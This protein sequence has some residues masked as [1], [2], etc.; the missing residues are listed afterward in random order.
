MIERGFSEQDVAWVLA[1]PDS[2]TL[3]DGVKLKAVR[4]RTPHLDYVVVYEA[5]GND[6]KIVTV[7][8]RRK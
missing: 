7:Y 3:S 8:K 2:C 5:S 1:R 4:Q 6:A